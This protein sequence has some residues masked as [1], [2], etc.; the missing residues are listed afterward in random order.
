MLNRI[1]MLMLLLLWVP[2]QAVLCF[3]VMWPKI[4]IAGPDP[5]STTTNIENRG[6]K[7]VMVVLDGVN[8][9]AVIVITLYRV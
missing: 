7:R 6:N 2:F 4:I 9:V 5:T 1:V 8:I 3:I